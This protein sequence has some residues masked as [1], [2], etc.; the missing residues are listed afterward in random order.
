MKLAELWALLKKSVNAWIEDYAPSMGAAL[1][2]Y[3]L[4]SIAPVLVI[5]IAVAG[6][7]FGQEAA[8]GEITAQLQG[9]LGDE[10]AVAVQGLLESASEP[11]EGILA[12][13]GSVVI[14]ILGATTVFGELQSA[15]DRIWKAPAIEQQSGIWTL[16]RTRLLSLGMVLVIGFLLLT[17]LVLSAALAAL[18]KW[19]GGLFGSWEVL[20]HIINFAVSFAIITGLFAMIYKILPR[21]DIGWHDVWIG[22]AVTALLFTLGKFLIGLYIGKSGVASG[23]GAAGS[24]VVLLVW[25]YYST[26]IFL[27]G[28]EFTWVY[29]HAHG[30]RAGA[31]AKAPA[32]GT[33]ISGHDGARE[34][35]ARPERAPTHNVLHPPTVADSPVEVRRGA[36]PIISRDTTGISAQAREFFRDNP[37]KGLGMLATAGLLMGGL[38]RQATS[39]GDSEDRKPQRRAR[40]WRSA[41]KQSLPSLTSRLAPRGAERPSL[42]ARLFGKF[43]PRSGRP[44][45][46]R[47]LLLAAFTRLLA[48][49]FV[50]KRIATK[51]NTLTKSMILW[52]AGHWI[53]R[54]RHMSH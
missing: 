30:S 35:A 44:P 31:S 41:A 9:L 19:W 40:A 52:L 42:A 32:V 47:G 25:V 45:V 34:L 26:Q 2:Y 53:D 43:S 36:M 17:S 27:L 48:T 1:A 24:F 3:T 13:I 15:L 46:L 51:K 5:V 23:F 38:L 21:V 33:E 11:T 20:L 7:F 12:T 18:G 28:A 16:I 10:G 14:L 39:R 50:R 54:S 8:Q 22:A 4:F 49:G 37:V 6:F 29:S